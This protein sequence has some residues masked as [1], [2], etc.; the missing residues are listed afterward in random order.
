MT[1]MRLAGVTLLLGSVA[2]ATLQP[3]RDPARF[4]AETKPEVL[5]V[6][7]KNGAIVDV[8]QPRISGDSLFGTRP[9][10]ARQVVLPMSQIARIEAVQHD[11][12]RTFY[13]IAGMTAVTATLG[14][15]MLQPANGDGPS[16]DTTSRYQ[17]D[18][19]CR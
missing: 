2:C 14:Y 12:K 5:H 19:G 4:I 16:C 10:M 3:V 11:R 13:I 15:L 1:G 8:A 18:P 6:L 9:G 7:H 17:W